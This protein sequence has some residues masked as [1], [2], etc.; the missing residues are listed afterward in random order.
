LIP[1]WVISGENVKDCYRSALAEAGF[2]IIELFT[3]IETYVVPSMEILAG[4]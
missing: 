4:K 1:P 2:E 3:K